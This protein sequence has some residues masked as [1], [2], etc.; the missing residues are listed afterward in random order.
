M[1]SGWYSA[2]DVK[3]WSEE[4][5]IR[6]KNCRFFLDMKYVQYKNYFQRRAEANKWY[7]LL[8]ENIPFELLSE[9]ENRLKRVNIITDL[10]QFENVLQHYLWFI[11]DYIKV[12]DY[13]KEK[14]LCGLYKHVNKYQQKEQFDQDLLNIKLQKDLNTTMQQYRFEKLTEL[15]SFGSKEWEEQKNQKIPNYTPAPKYI[16]SQPPIEQVEYM[17]YILSKYDKFHGYYEALIEGHEH[18]RM[19]YSESIK[20]LEIKVEK[21]FE[22]MVN[23]IYNKDNNPLG[24]MEMEPNIDI[25]QVSKAMNN[26]NSPL[27]RREIF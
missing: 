16:R 19:M 12:D 1:A 24:K 25:S 13:Q 11:Q 9:L 23:E 17:G 6:F 14:F 22:E 8:I 21:A 10:K 7:K 26:Q 5:L 3:R 2:D 20:D 27:N 18:V 4:D 15:K